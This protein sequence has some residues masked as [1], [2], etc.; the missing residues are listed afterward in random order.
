[1]IVK[2]YNKLVRDKIPEIIENSGRKAVVEKVSEE[3]Y[4]LLLHKKLEE[5]CKEYIENKDVKEL[6]DLVE[7]I[8]AILEYN[9]VPV[10]EFE[11]MRIEKAV[12]RGTFKE[13]YLLKEVIE[14]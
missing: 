10:K 2:K 9:S 1:M 12:N 7:V 14:G 3:A 6:V 11:K 8:R 13:R 4:I 5:E